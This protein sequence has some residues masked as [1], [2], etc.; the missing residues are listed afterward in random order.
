MI[1]LFFVRE[2][3]GGGENAKKGNAARSAEDFPQHEL[4]NAA[5]RAILRFRER[6]DAAAQRGARDAPVGAAH[7]ERRRLLRLHGIFQPFDVENFRAVESERVR[8]FAVGEFERNHAHA[9]QVGAVNALEAARDDGAHAEQRRA[10][11][12]PVARRAHA[13]IRAGEDDERRSRALV[14]F[15]RLEN[16]RQRSRGL[17]FREAA[18]L[19]VRHFVFDAH[20]REGAAHHD[21]VV[22]AAGAVGVEFFA[23]NAA[24]R[25]VFPGGRLRRKR[26]RGRN[27]IRRHGIAEN[28]QRAHSRERR[29]RRKLFRKAV[30]I[31]RELNVGRVFAPAEKRAARRRNVFPLRRRVVERSVALREHFRTHGGGDRRVDF[32]ARRPNV[33]EEDGSAVRSRAERLFFQIDVDAPRQ[34][35][36]DDERRRHQEIRFHERMNARLEIA[37]AGKHARRDEIA[38]AD[39]GLDFRRERPGIADAGR[40]AVA[41]DL[42]LLRAR[43]HGR[44]LLEGNLQPF[45]AVGQ[46]GDFHLRAHLPVRHAHRVLPGQ[47]LPAARRNARQRI[48]RELRLLAHRIL[49]LHGEMPA[50]VLQSRRI[51]HG[52]CVQRHFKLMDG[53][54]RDRHRLRRDDRH[55]LSVFGVCKLHA[56]R[57]HHERLVF[58]SVFP[59]ER[60]PDGVILC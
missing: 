20:V 5:R 35:E 43:V 3:N 44:G 18:F 19:A 25:Q 12:R 57:P 46:D 22:P 15:A 37:V 45:H 24:L 21:A 17:Q 58:R 1:Q 2:K 59:E 38:F 30:E 9:D 8:A 56:V 33:A 55:R 7:D 28:R 32:R 13:V 47:V 6:V 41:D 26:S 23:G 4:Q 34:R 54:R 29:R 39:R 50:Q 14:G 11:R 31:R 40:A 42:R 51:V 10:L 53:I 48:A 60:H 16:R 27:V 49:A 36:G 52:R